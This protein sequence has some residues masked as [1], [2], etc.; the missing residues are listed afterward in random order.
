[1]LPEETGI[2]RVTRGRILNELETRRWVIREGKVCEI[3]QLGSQVIEEFTSLAAMMA[4]ERRLGDV[5]DRFRAAG[6]GFAIDRLAD[7]ESTRVHRADATAPISRIAERFSLGGR[8]R[9]FSFVI[10]GEAPTSCRLNVMDGEISRRWVFADSVLEVITTPPPMA[11]QSR[12]MLE[13]G[14]AQYRHFSSDIPHVVVITNACVDLR[15]A[16][17][18]DAATALLQSDDGAVGSW[19]DRIFESYWAEDAPVDSA[20]FIA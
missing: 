2:T 3:T 20:V 13:T 16:D 12:A 6:C 19:A 8:I 10:T 1:M 11:R 7:D 17:E 9:A 5:I 4:A 14:R 15:P 18:D